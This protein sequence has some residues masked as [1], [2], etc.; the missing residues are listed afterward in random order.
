MTRRTGFA[1]VFTMSYSER[2]HSISLQIYV[3]FLLLQSNWPVF[4]TIFSSKVQIVF[5]KSISKSVDFEKRQIS[6]RMHY[7]CTDDTILPQYCTTCAQIE[8]RFPQYCTACGHM[9][10]SRH[11]IVLLVDTWYNLVAILYCLWTLSTI[12]SQ[13]CTTCGHLI[14]SPS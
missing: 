14:Q 3:L 2:V 10:Q 7:L 8:Q 9:I 13:Y 4:F 12:S 1:N 11:N 5:A 6:P